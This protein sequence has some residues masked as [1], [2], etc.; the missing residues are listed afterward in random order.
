MT[1]EF[2]TPSVSTALVTPFHRNGTVDLEKLEKLV[3]FEVAHGV[4]GLVPC[5]TTG[6]APTLSD[7][8]T[9]AVLE[10]TIAA[11]RGAAVIAGTGSN[12]T[13]KA[14]HATELA[15]KLG[16]DAALVVDSYYNG[17]S[18]LEL[19]TEYYERVLTVELPII[20]Y[21]I[22]GRTGCA[23]AAADLALLHLAAPARVPAVKEATGDLARMRADRAAAGPGLVILSGDD[24]L[25]LPM[26]RDAEIGAAGVISVMANLV[27]RAVSDLVGAARKH[28]WAAADRLAAALAPLFDIVG[29]KV[30]SARL[31]PDGRSIEVLDVFRNPVPIKA[32]MAGLG[33]IEPVFRAPHGRMSKEGVAACRSAALAVHREHPGVFAPAAEF[34]G[35]DVAA[36]LANDAAWSALAR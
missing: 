34:F 4:E 20:P 28:D 19:R 26:M 1:R 36:R 3:E 7:D 31:L 14:V 12:A 11:K 30:K 9:R 17:P 8:E 27:P 15:K 24:A 6:E 33:I 25:T 32:I 21:V 5:G 23:L 29:C 18:S 22:P 35:V 2:R 13:H 10:T 16:A